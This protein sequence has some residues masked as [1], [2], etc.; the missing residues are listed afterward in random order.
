MKIIIGATGT[1]GKAVAE[2]LAARHEVLRASRKNTLRVDFED[3]GSVAAMFDKI[4]NV[5]AVVSCGGHVRGERGH[6]GAGG[7]IEILEINK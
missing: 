7:V 1:I 2:A 3:A 4:Q 6:I 5:D